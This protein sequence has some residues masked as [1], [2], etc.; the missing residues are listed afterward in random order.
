MSPDPWNVHVAEMMADYGTRSP[1]CIHCG[2]SV[3][4]SLQGFFGGGTWTANANNEG[5]CFGGNL[6][7][8]EGTR[9]ASSPSGEH[10]VVPPS[11]WFTTS[12]EVGTR[13]SRTVRPCR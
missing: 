10:E 7:D 13:K 8:V 12:E 5:P 3:W 9:C 4:M 6:V 11:W 1:A 2:E